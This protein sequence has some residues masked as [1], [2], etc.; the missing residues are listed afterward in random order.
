MHRLGGMR[1]IPVLAFALG[2][3]LTS[4][5]VVSAASM[6]P[7]PA[8]SNASEGTLALTSPAVAPGGSGTLT[9]NLSNPF[10]KEIS[11]LTWSLDLYFWTAMDNSSA[12][13]IGPSDGWAP[14]LAVG[15]NSPSARISASAASLSPGTTRSVDVEV[16]VP[17]G[18]PAGSYFLRSAMNVT[19]SNGTMYVFQSRGFFSNSLWQEATVASGNRSTLNL[20]MLNVSGISPETSI[21][22]SSGGVALWIWG[23]LGMALILGGIGGYLW[24]RSDRQEA[25]TSGARSLRRRK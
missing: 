6:P 23:I 18:C 19:L 2:I 22:V 12:G 15:G 10:S 24:M 7:A 11:T 4:T 14:H 5:P 8:P 17:S 16:S 21:I 1:A 25:S 20:T 13:A 3:L 9:L